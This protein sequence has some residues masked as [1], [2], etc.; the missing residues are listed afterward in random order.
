MRKFFTARLGLLAGGHLAIDAY[1]SFFS[2]LL[3]LLV[4]KLHLN[5]TRVGALVALASVTSSFAQPVFGM[6]SDRVRRPWF[7]AFGPLTAAVFMSALGLAPTYGALVALLMLG[8]LGVAAFHPQAAS[9][10]SMVSPRRG[11]AM[12]FF[13]TGGTLGFALGPLFAV[14][15]VSA[16]GLDR[17]WIAVFPGLVVSA[18][19]LA[20]FA[21]VRP[22]AHHEIVRPPLSELRPVLRPLTLLY[23]AV[24]CRSA[25]SYGFMTFLPLYLN[26]RGYSL[27]RGGMVVSI[28]L[29]MGAIGG[30]VG[31]WLADRWGGR[32]V[33]VT[34][35][36]GSIPL[37][38]GFLFLPDRLGLP[39]L[40][41][42]G[43]VLQAS[44]PVNVVLGQELAPRHSSTIASL[45]M[46][47]AWG[48]GALLIGP[49]GAFADQRGLH[50]ALLAL[51][52]MLAGGLACAVLL[53]AT[54]GHM[55]LVDT[56]QPAGSAGGD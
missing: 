10:A 46:G 19:L 12:A 56:A 41:L 1:S 16:F 11:M 55:V 48:V 21:R 15:V 34:S 26:A 14:G 2:P 47:A 50:A 24:V 23:L 35:F 43:F 17:T 52:C 7:V 32:R 6:L 31:G 20:W 30:F 5:L 29:L 3:P 33:I 40:V 51:S 38:L 42:G 28:Y 39:S 18:L 44:L 8:G 9:L 13:V 53:P 54:R 45:L 27:A 22:L 49:T 4:T 25:V 36:V 37:Y